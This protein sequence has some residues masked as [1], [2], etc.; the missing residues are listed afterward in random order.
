MIEFYKEFQPLT[1]EEPQWNWFYSFLDRHE[2]KTMN[3]KVMD[4]KRIDNGTTGTIKYWFE[5][6]YLPIDPLSIDKNLMF[7]YDETMLYVKNNGVVVVRKGS[8]QGI[9]EEC[10]GSEH[11]T[12][13]VSMS[14]A[15]NYTTPFIIVPLKKCPKSL[16]E[17]V[18]SGHIALGGQD[19]GWIDK[20]L[21]EK[22]VDSFIDYVKS[23]REKLGLQ[24]KKAVLILDGHSS[25]ISSIAAK[26]LEENNI[27]EITLPPHTS[28]ILQA[29]DVGIFK[30]F[31]QYF[32]KLYRSYANQEFY[33]DDGEKLD[34]TNQKRVKIV[35]SAIDAFK[36][37]FILRN[38]TKSFAISGIYPPSIEEACK[39][40]Y[41]RKSDEN[42]L[43]IKSNKSSNKSID[44]GGMLLNSQ[45]MIKKL[46]EHE[47][48]VAEKNN[49]KRK[50][51]VNFH[52][53]IN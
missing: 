8:K 28:H 14:V 12:S 17:Y 16:M 3:G 23:T 7:N 18:N 38:I 13:C 40:Q 22:W 41:V 35:L 36:Q 33:Y 29:L 25:R 2:L 1:I 15:G 10:L 53:L 44:I 30:D 11:I 19:S 6:T 51:E 27:L 46:Q 31:K 42:W 39:N 21:F 48:K 24:G 50:S 32:K 20:T 26:K 43:T 9:I 4:K 37:S 34:D 49:K 5:K 45:E 52:K 47:S